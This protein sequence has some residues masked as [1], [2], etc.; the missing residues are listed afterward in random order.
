MSRRH[1]FLFLFITSLILSAC[2]GSQTA[3]DVFEISSCSASKIESQFV[4][5][6][7]DGRVTVEKAKDKQAFF[8][9]FLNENANDVL[10]AE[11]NHR[12]VV[13]PPAN[14]SPDANNKLET[15]ASPVNWGVDKIEAAPVWN[16]AQGSGITVAVID[17]GAEVSHFQLSGQLHQNPGEVA[18]NGIDDD[19]NGKI[20]DVNGWDFVADS[21]NVTE[22]LVGDSHGTHV[23]GIIAA[24]HSGD[25]LI[26]GVAPQAKILPLN[27]MDASRGGTI[28]HAIEAIDYA[29]AQG[30]KVINASWGSAGCS[31]ILENKVAAL[32][33]QNVLFVAAAGNSG[34]N[35]RM[36]VD[37]N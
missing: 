23:A 25:G 1:P 17:S 31:S 32:A 36:N 14:N 15:F 35:I 2:G 3:E 13:A 34:N 22:V 4:V 6:W 37:K 7:K 11:H 20:D 21:G 29:V 18:G 30:A 19:G 16:H 9:E 8:D 24:A 33:D 28:G 26:K 12:V 5:E 27:F 10:H